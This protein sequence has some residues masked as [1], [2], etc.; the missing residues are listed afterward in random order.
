[1]TKGGIS[2][3]RQAIS[4][5]AAEKMAQESARGRSF[6]EQLRSGLSA[7]EK[8]QL[9]L[10]WQKQTHWLI[11][12]EE[13][14]FEVFR[15]NLV[16]S[17]EERNAL[18]VVQRAYMNYNKY[19]GKG[20]IAKQHEEQQVELAEHIK[21]VDAM[22]PS[23]Q[24]VPRL[25]NYEARVALAAELG[26]PKATVDDMMLKYE[27]LHA[28][29]SWLHREA[30]KGRRLPSTSAE[31]TWMMMARPTREVSRLNRLN[32]LRMMSKKDKL[33]RWYQKRKKVPPMWL[34][35]QDEER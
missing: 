21:I 22:T 13:F 4:S 15:Q 25:L 3:L 18:T 9:D 28:M 11:G 29:H 30:E 16:E 12:H 32:A 24:R 6:G 27:N 33:R 26:L 19:V 17:L 35:Y 1:M 7:Q 23:E 14:T 20:D 10:E 5:P 2:A 8:T 31:L 34:R